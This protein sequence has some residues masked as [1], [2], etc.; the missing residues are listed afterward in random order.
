MVAEITLTNFSANDFYFPFDES[1]GSNI[2]DSINGLTGTL[3]ANSPVRTNDTATEQ[4]GDYSLYFDGTKR[5]TV[6]DPD[7]V[8]GKNGT[9]GNYT[10][11]AWVKLPLNFVPPARMILF[12]YEY[13]PGFS[14]SIN[15]NRTLHT[16]TFNV[17]DV[18]STAALPND[19]QWHHVAVVHTDGVNMKFF[20]DATL[21]ATVNYTN[22]VGS[23]TSSAITIGSSAVGANPFTGVLDRISFDNQALSAAQL[24]F[25]AGIPL[26]VRNVEDALILFW[27]SSSNSGY[28]LQ[29]SSNFSSLV[30]SNVAHV[31]QGDENQAVVLPSN[32]AR[33][34][35]LRK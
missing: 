28:I 17:S 25:P 35:R 7:Q 10:L 22:G 26:G 27:P 12:Q 15:T 8:I 13:T 32:S 9:N 18:P 23:R 11:Q 19:E 24:D 6:P 16:T 30:W 21:A 29:T 4:T 1:S 31:V 14:F 2:F 33:F 3:G 20:I 5:V 34:F